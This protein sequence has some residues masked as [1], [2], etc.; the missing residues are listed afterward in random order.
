MAED[1]YNGKYCKDCVH[2]AVPLHM[3]GE[4]PRPFC[5]AVIIRYNSMDGPVHASL[6]NGRPKACGPD[7]IFFEAK[8]Q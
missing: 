7:G 5:S 1:K 6:Y 2:K 4:R 8:E 3:E